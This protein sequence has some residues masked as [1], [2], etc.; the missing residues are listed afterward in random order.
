[1]LDLGNLGRLQA[2]T[3]DLSERDVG[4]VAVGNPA[5]VYVKAL[6]TAIK[7]WVARIAPKSA[8]VGGDVVYTVVIELD[9]QPAD[10]RWGM[11]V[12]VEIA[13]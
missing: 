4:R 11:S 6:S 13:R 9:E 3:I 12:D 7:G 1:M 8:K 10:L 2:E 5:T